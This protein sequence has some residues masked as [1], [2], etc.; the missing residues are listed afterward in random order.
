MTHPLCNPRRSAA[1]H[2]TRLLDLESTTGRVRLIETE[3]DPAEGP[4]ITLSHRWPA[5]FDSSLILRDETHQQLLEGLALIRLPKLVQDAVTVCR[6][7]DIRYLWVDCMCI[8]QEQSAL[9]DWLE[10]SSLMEDVY[11][12]SYINLSA[13]ASTNTHSSLL[14]WGPP[15]DEGRLT[16][17]ARL[18][19][20]LDICR[21]SQGVPYRIYDRDLWALEVNGA[22]LNK[23]AWVLQERLSS[24]RTLHF[25]PCQ[26]YWECR[27]QTA[28]EMYPLGLP[29]QMDCDRNLKRSLEPYPDRIMNNK[30]QHE[31]W[32]RLV[33]YYSKC[34]LT[35]S[36]DKLVALSGL[37]KHAASIFK[38]DYVAGLWRSNLETDLFW[39]TLDIQ[40]AHEK[41]GTNTST[42]SRPSTRAKPYRGPSFSWAAINARIELSSNIEIDREILEV[43]DVELAYVTNEFGAVSGGHLDLR[44]ILQKIYFNYTYDLVWDDV[45][46]IN[47]KDVMKTSRSNKLVPTK[48]VLDLDDHLEHFDPR[49]RDDLYCVTNVFADHGPDEPNDVAHLLLQVVDA[50]QGIFQRFGVA[51]TWTQEI[52]ALEDVH[53]LCSVPPEAAY[54]PCISFDTEKQRHLIR[55]I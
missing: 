25:S 38:D 51:K 48:S 14:P 27:V 45:L 18:Y 3:V 1:W 13:V 7:L 39:V 44:C 52:Y 54:Y 32:N 16:A 2:P 20:H 6:R 40:R 33:Q 37:A 43:Q 10:Q 55:I 30:R 15:P 9:D 26:L 41:R 29:K 42:W 50:G 4:Y 8:I 36:S 34:G 28:S 21:L 22:P 47:G 12:Y 11:S 5:S 17:R 23:R 24:S 19:K 46:C 53:R 31:I 49:G 35:V